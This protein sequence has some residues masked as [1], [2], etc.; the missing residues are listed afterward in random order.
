[1]SERNRNVELETIEHKNV[2]IDNKTS[3]DNNSIAAA[4]NGMSNHANHENTILWV[5]D[6]GY[7]EW[8]S[9]VWVNIP[10]GMKVNIRIGDAHNPKFIN[11][12]KL[13]LLNIPSELISNW[14]RNEYK[15]VD[16]YKIEKL[17]SQTSNFL[18]GNSKESEGLSNIINA[19]LPEIN[20]INDLLL[21]ENFIEDHQTINTTNANFKQLLILADLVSKRNSN[22]KSA[23]KGKKNLISAII[24]K[25]PKSVAK[26]INM[27]KYQ[28]W[29]GFENA[30]NLAEN[31]LINWL[32]LNL[33]SK[34]DDL[35]KAKLVNDAISEYEGG[36]WWAI[37]IRN[38]LI[39]SF[40]EWRDS[41]AFSVW[42]WSLYDLNLTSLFEI[43][44]KKAELS[45]AET[46]PRLT[47]KTAESILDF[48][49]Q[50]NWF[51]LHGLTAVKVHTSKEAFSRHLVIDTD[52]THYEV[53][54]KMSDQIVSGDFIDLA[55]FL[56][57]ERLI[58]ISGNL[59]KKQPK[60]LTK[61]NVK[62]SSW[63]KIWIASVNEGADLWAGIPNPTQTLYEILDHISSGQDFN[64]GLLKSIGQSKNN[65]IINYPNRESIWA[66][67]PKN[68]YQNFLSTTSKSVLHKYLFGSIVLNN[69]EKPIVDQIT[70]DQ[71]MSDFLDQN[72]SDMKNVIAVYESFPNL[73][74]QFL[75]DYIEY[76]SQSLSDTECSRLGNVVRECK[77]RK[78]ARSIYERSKY[79]SSFSNA[80]NLCQNLV[81]LNFFEKNFGKS[82]LKVKQDKNNMTLPTIVI[83][84]AINVEYKAVKM[85]LKNIVEHTTSNGTIYEGGEFNFQGEKIA[86]IIIRE[87]GSKNTT[88]SHE[89]EKALSNFDPDMIFFVG[90][91]GSRKPHDFSI[92]DVI[93][94]EKVYYYESGKALKDSLL[95]RPDAV[96][97]SFDFIE[98]AKIERNNEGW[99]SL[100]KGTYDYSPKAN[101]GIIASGEQLVEHYDSA[102]G[103]IIYNH[104]NDAS[105]VEME[106]YGFL[107]VIER[108]GKKTKNITA[109]VVR[110]ISDI[111]EQ[112][113]DDKSLAIDRRPVNA[114]EFAS[115][116]AAAFAYWMILKLTR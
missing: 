9:R 33:F 85:H 12:E 107:K 109:G 40:K 73:K 75:A 115:D 5:G 81:D 93:F 99:K 69:I 67:L 57:D 16:G 46:V 7:F 48:A 83:L 45:L 96:A 51:Y 74:D 114:Q 41:Y 106:N 31:S 15:I 112:E 14:S 28:S 79:N 95:A 52:Q 54:Q 30:K 3:L 70:S 82:P 71:F 44:P 20:V 116:S 61:L 108:Q 62:N 17:D 29:K 27:L 18:A 77:F 87:T 34:G 4:I 2:K 98:R 59:I 19:Y 113:G 10:S 63:Q 24:S 32:E 68:C 84:T 91:A 66:I 13:N 25:I 101:L 76:Y 65:D 103:K 56:S 53:L 58:S 23:V 105:A 43:L 50:K 60:L 26:E 97:P 6:S 80:Y 89:T 21:F 37:T 110:G 78:S 1:M 86:N 11:T 8:I 92:G 104:Y 90:I 36:N 55:I 42:N 39:A 72:K 49:R 102:V 38:Y 35:D 94:P 100:M 22:S 88:A 111:L 47:R 64:N